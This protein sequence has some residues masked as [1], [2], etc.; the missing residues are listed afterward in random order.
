MPIS[1]LA[2]CRL[3]HHSEFLTNL[4]GVGLVLLR[5]EAACKGRVHLV[6]NLYALRRDVDGIPS[7]QTA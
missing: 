1:G 6:T 5:V 2:Y 7:E 3:D 4:A